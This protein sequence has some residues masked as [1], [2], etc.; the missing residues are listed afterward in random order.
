MSS[1]I[2]AKSH[3]VEDPKLFVKYRPSHFFMLGNAM[4]D[5][6]AERGA[7]I[8]QVSDLIASEVLFQFSMVIKVHHRL[9]DLLIP[10]LAKRQDVCKETIGWNLPLVGARL[11]S[12]HDLA[13]PF[14]P[15]CFKRGW[16]PKGAAEA[17]CIKSACVGFH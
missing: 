14:I 12:A 1:C 3:C 5:W 10:I 15:F 11:A 13:S 9:V 4:A 2:W 7:L 16:G 6:L 8:C 17:R